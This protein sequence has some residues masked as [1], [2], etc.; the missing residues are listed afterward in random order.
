MS[1]N[2]FEN[3][4]SSDQLSGRNIIRTAIEEYS[5]GK[6]D[7]GKFDKTVNEVYP[8]GTNASRNEVHVEVIECLAQL[9]LEG[10]VNPNEVV[11][12]IEPLSAFSSLNK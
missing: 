2:E 8:H 6:I 3:N 11:E 5:L 7:F 1:S 10:R 12:R 4:K 9:N